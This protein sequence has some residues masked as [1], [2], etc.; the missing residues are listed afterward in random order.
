MSGKSDHEFRLVWGEKARNNNWNH[1]HQP[2]F[3]I[4]E[5]ERERVSRSNISQAGIF[6]ARITYTNR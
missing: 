2:W 1:E 5:R 4:N 3:V 6:F